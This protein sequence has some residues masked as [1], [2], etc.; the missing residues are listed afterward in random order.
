[1]EKDTEDYVMQLEKRIVYL[2]GRVSLLEAQLATSKPMPTYPSH[3]HNPQMPYIPGI[4]T[5][6]SDAKPKWPGISTTM[7]EPHLNTSEIKAYN[8]MNRGD[9][10]L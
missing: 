3:P 2:E 8:P 4:I 6:E 1:M 5:A 7:L 10:D 9:L